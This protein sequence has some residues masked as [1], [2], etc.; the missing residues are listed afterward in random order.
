MKI[1]GQFLPLLKLMLGIC[2]FGP[3]PLLFWY[4]AFGLVLYFGVDAF[5]MVWMN[6]H[7]QP[8]AD[9]V[10]ATCATLWFFLMLISTPLAS[11]LLGG[12]TSLEFLFTRAIDRALW[13]RAERAAV[14]VIVVAPLVLN[15]T[16]SPWEPKMAF[17]PAAQGSDAAALQAQYVQAFPGS[18]VTSLAAEAGLGPQ[19][20]I[21]HG[22]EMFA[23]WL[24][25]LALVGIFLVA[26]YFTLAFTA[27]QRAD[28]HHSKSPWRPWLGAAMI[29]APTYSVIPLFIYSH[30]TRVRFDEAS[31]LFFA[32]HPLA[33]TLALLA[34]I[35]IVQPLS[36]RN[37]KKLEFEFN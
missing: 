21:P 18:H 22:T 15:L 32:R 13:L 8:G 34:L 31:F 5:P 4:L 23:L 1:P 20:V 2:R 28:W 25:W 16:L 11:Q 14:I 30:V 35:L 29:Y 6:D 10:I 36:E 3:I 24:V 12:L 7:A 17:E 37:I 33:L 26:G 19:L 9:E 27:W